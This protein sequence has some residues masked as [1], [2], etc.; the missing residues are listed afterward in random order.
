MLASRKNTGPDRESNNNEFRLDQ[1]GGEIGAEKQKQSIS[2]FFFFLSRLE[3]G[4]ELSRIA[5]GAQ[6]K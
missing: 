5:T 4:E 2:R 6:A 1:L 3:A